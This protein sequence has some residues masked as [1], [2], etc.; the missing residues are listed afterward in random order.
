MV[1][2]TKLMAASRFVV[3]TS[4]FMVALRLVFTV[5]SERPAAALQ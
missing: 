4:R 1:I 3:A 2:V 5:V